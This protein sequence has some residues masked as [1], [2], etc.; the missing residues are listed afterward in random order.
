MRTKCSETL[1]RSRVNGLQVDIRDLVASERYEITKEI[2]A[3]LRLHFEDALHSVEQINDLD[4]AL[5]TI[6]SRVGQTVARL[7][8]KEPSRFISHCSTISMHHPSMAHG[9]GGNS[10]KAAPRST[11][12]YARIWKLDPYGNDAEVSIFCSWSAILL[13]LMVHKSFCTL[14]H[15]L[16]RD[17]AMALNQ[18]IRSK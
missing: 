15:P 1:C 12:S 3:I 9:G 13:H 6:C 14:Y 18:S 5:K 10:T 8:P 17:S 11:E 4:N 7:L 16:F 2:R